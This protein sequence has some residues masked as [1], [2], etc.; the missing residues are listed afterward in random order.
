MKTN[1][2][3]YARILISVA[4]LSVIAL[5]RP[6]SA[7]GIAAP[8]LEGFN[9]K[10]RLIGGTASGATPG[11]PST[12][13]GVEIAMPEGWKTYWRAPGESGIPPEFDWSA[14][15]NLQSATVLYPAPHRLVDKGGANIGYKDHILF[16]AQIVAKDPAK[17]VLLKLKTAFG[18]CKEL[19]VP[20][21]AELEL[22]LPPD[23]GS[24]PAISDALASVPRLKP[25]AATDP[26]LSKW[27]VD[28]KAGKPTLVLEVSD[29]GGADGD[30]FVDMPGGTYLPLPVKQPDANGH[31]VY[32]VNLTEGADFKDLKGKLLT[33]TLTG[34]KGQSETKITLP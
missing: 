7:D 13:A 5:A 18:V 34:V 26:S 6:A 25:V 1:L 33:V 20:V 23:V 21:E 12:Y 24:E 3:S 27:R 14:S 31:N 17:P 8:W 11:A 15:E 28:D 32:E 2:S 10:V 4:A 19:C 29:P 16:P 9:N 30:A 22:P